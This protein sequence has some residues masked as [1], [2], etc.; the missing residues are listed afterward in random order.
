MTS[1][2]KPAHWLDLTHECALEPGLPICDPHHHLWDVP[3]HRSQRYLL[4]ELLA[5]IARAFALGHGVVVAGPGGIGK[6]RLLAQAAAAMEPAIEPP[7]EPA[8]EG[9]AT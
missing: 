4:D 3:Q 2:A 1:T 5:D 8:M 9:P 7:M 6:S